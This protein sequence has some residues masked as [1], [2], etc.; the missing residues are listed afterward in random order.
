MDAIFT[1]ISAASF[2]LFL[3]SIMAVI[4]FMGFASAFYVCFGMELESWKTLGDSLGSLMRIL[5]GDFDYPE[6]QETNKIMAPLLFY[7]F[8]FVSFFVLLN[9]FIAI[10]CDSYADVKAAQDDEDLRF[11]ENLFRS[12]Q[13]SIANFLRRKEAIHEITKEMKSADKDNDNRIDEEELREALKDNPEALQL[14]DTTTIK[15]LLQ[16]YDIDEDGVLDKEEMVKILEDLAAKEGEIQKEI[17]RVKNDGVTGGDDGRHGGGYGV[18]EYERSR[19][20]A[21]RQHGSAGHGAG[22]E[23][24]FGGE[25]GQNVAARLDRVESQVKDMSRNMAK[26]LS[27]MIDLIMSVSDQL[28]N[29]S[30]R[31]MQPG[32]PTRAQV[33]P[34]N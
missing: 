3:F 16:K 34:L 4:I 18:G 30:Q 13:S 26:K 32:Q 28:T 25:G 24:L 6:L 20:R 7:L 23:A 15:E 11:Y 33:V 9:M 22:G 12:I 27:L 8:I 1:T 2:D 17:S 21:I 14:L 10:I 19:I 29:S 5:L 31:H